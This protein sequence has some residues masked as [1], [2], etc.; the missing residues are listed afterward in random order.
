M[1]KGMDKEVLLNFLNEEHKNSF[2]EKEIVIRTGLT[3]M[4]LIDQALSY[5]HL[6]NHLK[7]LTRLN[8]F[9]VNEYKKIEAMIK[10]EDFET[11]SLATKI[12]NTKM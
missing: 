1:T 4:S 12:I 8:K 5:E 9:T 7:D 11:V 2:K 6:H 10:S 3:G